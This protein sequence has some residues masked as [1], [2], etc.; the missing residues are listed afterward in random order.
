MLRFKLHVTEELPELNGFILKQRM[1]NYQ[2]HDGRQLLWL[3]IE[4][5][6]KH[7]C[8]HLYTYKRMLE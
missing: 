2:T 8:C 1:V 5:V 6:V 3:L 7:G 4:V